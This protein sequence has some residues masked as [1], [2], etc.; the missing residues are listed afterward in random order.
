[1]ALLGLAAGLGRP[2]GEACCLTLEIGEPPGQG[3]PNPIPVHQA[4]ALRGQPASAGA[5]SQRWC[6]DPDPRQPGP[7]GPFRPE[8][9]ALPPASAPLPVGGQRES[10]LLASS[11]R[12]ELLIP[13][14]LSQL[15][16]TDIPNLRGPATQTL[17]TQR[18]SGLAP[19]PKC[20]R[21]GPEGS[22]QGLLLA[23]FLSQGFIQEVTDPCFRRGRQK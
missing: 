4:L 23:G 19:A 14:S 1:M 12:E 20:L 21:T 8:F 22:D 2:S 13:G 5:A 10:T 17:H 9:P 18:S 16:V 3:L 11:P 15:V 6:R 7:H